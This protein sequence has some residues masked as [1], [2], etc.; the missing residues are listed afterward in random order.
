V[1]Y[2]SIE[3]IA[4]REAEGIQVI[5][6]AQQLERVL[7]VAVGKFTLQFSQAGDLNRGVPGVG[8]DCR[9]GNRESEDQTESWRPGG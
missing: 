5:L 9:D 8:H 6:D 2:V 7:P 4:H 1:L 3:H